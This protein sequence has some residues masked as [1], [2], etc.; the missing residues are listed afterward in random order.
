MARN[1]AD[2]A[3]EA[4][5]RVEAPALTVLTYNVLAPCYRRMPRRKL[6]GLGSRERESSLDEVWRARQAEVLDLVASA[7]PRP[8]VVCLQEYW[9]DPACAAL[10]EAALGGE[11]DFAVVRRPRKA[12]A[13]ACLV[14]R[15][16]RAAL[17]AWRGIV[18]PYSGQRVAL[19]MHLDVRGV[20]DVVFTGLHLQY[21]GS[22]LENRA[23]SHQAEHFVKESRRLRGEWGVSEAAPMLFA[24]DFN[25]SGDADRVQAAMGAA[26]LRSCFRAVHGREAGVTHRCHRDRQFCADLVLVAGDGLR[27]RSA[28]LLPRGL[29]DHEWPHEDAYSA[30]DHRPL[31]VEFA[32]GGTLQQK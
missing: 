22:V 19:A 17:R 12:D 9:T 27:P 28:D 16:G 31:L 13:V 2:E 3:D 32:P 29:P 26:G 15:G 20:G 25:G 1:E 21:P 7:T 24:G 4:R 18:A 14:R 8:D 23:R 10:Y 11:Y 5:G 30:S 6:R